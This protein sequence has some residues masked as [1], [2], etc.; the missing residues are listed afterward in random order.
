MSTLETQV[1]LDLGEIRASDGELA[2]G[3]AANLGELSAA[4]FRVPPGFCISTLAYDEV[5]RELTGDLIDRLPGAAAE[6][7]S[8]LAGAEIPAELAAAITAAYAELGPDAPVAVRSSATAED[9]PHASFAGQ[10]DTYLNVIGEA[11]LLDAVRRCWSSLWTDRAVAYRAANDIDHRAVRLAVVV[12]R[13]VDATAAG[14]LFTANPVTGRRTET[15]ID[16]NTG[17][18]ESVVSGAVTPDHFAVE[19]G[20]IT[21][22]RLGDKPTSVHPKPGG[23]T[24]TVAQQGDQPSITDDQARALAALG[25]EV[26][27]H[28][29]APQDIEWAIDGD[30]TPWLTQSRPIT[31]LFP[32]PAEPH[33]GLH[34]YLSINVAQGVY[35]PITPM[36]A[37]TLA[38]MF[39]NLMRNLGI[40]TDGPRPKLWRQAD[41]WLFADI[42]GMTRNKIGRAVAPKVFAMA[43]ARTGK[44][45]ESLLDDPRLPL[46]PKVPWPLLRRLAGIFARTKAPIEAVRTLRDPKRARERIFGLAREIRAEL[47][48]PEPSSA[49][50]RLAAARRSVAEI[51]VPRIAQIPPRM[52]PAVVL[53]RLLPKLA[54]KAASFEEVQIVLRGIP[55][56]VTTEMDLELWGIAQLASRDPETAR[57]F[58][59]SSIDELAERYQD[60]KLPVEVQNGLDAFFERYGHRTV[61][62]IDIGIPRWSEAPAHVLGLVANY[63]QTGESGHDADEQY[64]R[65]VADAER[66]AAEIVSRLKNPLRARVVGFAMDRVRQLAGLREMPKYCIVLTIANA[67][68]HLLAVGRELACTGGLERAEDV[69]FLDYDELAEAVSGAD[70]RNLVAKRRETHERELRRRH[71]PRVLLSDGTEPEATLPTAAVDGQL[72]GTSASAGTVTGTA[73]VVHD[74]VRA[75]LAPGEI[76]VT[77]STDPGWTPLFLTAGGLVMEMGGPNSHGATVAREYGIPAVVGVPEATTRITDGQRI[78]VHGSAGTVELDR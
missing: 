32:L 71:P 78:T 67:R 43:E 51:A 55:H 77:P 73:R 5:C 39:N 14:V 29:G 20:R 63:V 1:L 60:R 10:Q 16:A 56:N 40:P 30:G 46:G 24:E 35:R 9:L 68:K 38:L 41:G 12:Q 61:A 47:A 33:G 34:V 66:M 36:G 42:T 19:S 53:S 31:T 48:G 50:E 26:A 23:G 7:R 74:P 2:G 15:V 75:R 17:L 64:R 62:E 57:L 52:L 70:H 65:G 22:R 76:L 54:G 45:F 21:A 72:I 4:G 8:R 49:R 6:I 18:G 59:G 69:F 13:M 37:A 28:C 11:A 58:A 25:S 27:R 44:V 3:K